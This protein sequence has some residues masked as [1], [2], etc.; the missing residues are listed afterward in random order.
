MIKNYFYLFLLLFIS[1][2][3]FGQGCT[4]TI[5]YVGTPFCT[6]EGVQTVTLSGTGTY[7]G[8]TFTAPAGLSINASTGAITPGSSIEGMYIVTYAIPASGGCAAVSATTN[9]TI[10]SSATASISYASSAFC[11][12]S[13]NYD[14]NLI[15]TLDY[16]NGTF[17][18]S[19]AG[20]IIDPDTGRINTGGSTNPGTYTVTY[21]IPA[22]GVCP[23]IA[24]TTSVTITAKPTATISYPGTPFC[25]SVTTEQNVIL[26]GTAAYTGG[27]F[28]APQG[29]SIN[30][31]TGA[32]APS[33]STAGTYTVTYAIP[34][35]GGCAGKNVTTDVTITALPTA[36]I[37]YAGTPFC[38]SVTTGQNVSLS[39]TAAYTGGTFAAAPSGLT[40]SPTSGVITPST[41]AAGT[42]SITYTTP[43]SAGCAAVSVTTSVTI[44]KSPTATINYAGTPFCTSITGTQSATLNGTDAYTG[45]SFSSSPAGL[46]IDAATGDITPSASTAGTYTVT[47]T[48]PANGGCAAIPVTTNVTITALPTAVISYAGIPLCTAVTTG[49]NVTL[50][51]TGAYT[52]GTYSATR[53]GLTINPSTGAITPSTSTPG[54]YNITYVVPASGGCAAVSVTTGVTITTAPTATISYAGTPF[55]KSIAGTQSTTLN[56]TGAYTGGTYSAPAGLSINASTG[57]ITP[58]S[59]IAGTYT[60]TYTIPA[61]NDCIAILVTT[62][63]TITDIPIA[64]ISYPG[65]PF[66]KSLGSKNVTLI[67]TG[68]YNG[69]TYSVTPAGLT[70]DALAGTITPSTSTVGTYTVTYTIPTSGGCAAVPVTTTVIIVPDPVGG[71]VSLSNSSIISSV[72]ECFTASGTLYLSGHVG[73]IIKWQSSVTTGTSWVDIANTDNTLTYSGITQSTIFRAVIQNGGCSSVISNSCVISVLPNIKPSPVTASA[74]TICAGESSELSSTSG[75]ATSM[76]LATGGTFDSPIPSG[77]YVD[78]CADCLISGGSN[79]VPGPWQLSSSNGNTYSGVD[80]TSIGKFAIAHGEGITSYMYTP[81]FNTFGLTNATLT[82]K[83]AYNFLAG[84]RGEIQI[85]V[86]GGSTYTTIQTYTGTLSPTNPFTAPANDTAVDLNAYLGQGNLKIRF[87]YHGLNTASSWAIDNIAIPD[88]P[89]NLNTQW[90][91]AATGVVIGSGNT[92]TVT[93]S[94]TT[95]YAVT[96]SLNGCN[97]FGTEGIAYV[98]V[99]VNPRPT[100]VI[101]QNQ[102]VCN[103]GTATFS[104][105]LTGSGPWELK[106]FNGTT[107]TTV[108]DILISPYVF[109]VA[110]M[111]NTETYTI[112]YLKDSICTAIATDIAGSATVTVLSGTA[113]LWTGLVSTDWFD[114]LNWTCGLPSATI[115]AQ[116]PT[117]AAIMPVID[118]LSPFAATNGPIAV[119]RD[120]II[121]TNASITM[122]ANSDLH[123]KRD[124]RNSGSF[125][126]GSG[127]VTFNG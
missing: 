3:C 88:V 12:K 50:S 120:V 10:A 69:G 47:Y 103:G 93:P 110:D 1:I 63:I 19:P 35:S 109:T 9:V 104:I 13:G 74:S 105:A 86:D 64:T 122:A 97:S 84:A 8:G 102:T 34:A 41:S 81:I 76:G 49:Q 106:Y 96:S 56:G 118:P 116:I 77:W 54:T 99:T 24:A 53:A 20:L 94:V 72:T 117:G 45:G 115:D 100:A 38:T 57:D 67:G 5:S 119:A 58:S 46:S 112:T 121:A 75:Y 43:A 17:S 61:S 59:S 44:T 126:P 101:N 127:T 16:A 4:A 11:E 87:Y 85:S 70:I 114:T 26:T 7:T 79:D 62:S 42:Y 2:F 90:K 29:L 83:H 28:S 108:N 80:Y 78:G 89:T 32:I 73:N 55:C 33:S 113:G 51:G 91:N 39:G 23:P 21:T 52:G 66:C 68:A 125:I 6:S 22:R 92:V 15:G 82:F 36:A 111:T 31:V 30:S 124:W 65:T 95:T 18:A 25:T 107:S 123:V 37:S 40:I 14:I 48:I 98:T 71:S 27:T 60:V